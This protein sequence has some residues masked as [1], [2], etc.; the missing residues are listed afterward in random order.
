MRVQWQTPSDDGGVGISNYTLTLT[1]D[2]G[3]SRTKTTN[4][5]ERVLLFNYTTTYSVSVRASNCAGSSN[6]SSPIHV[7]QGYYYLQSTIY[8]II[9]DSSFHSPFLSQLAAV[10]HLFQSMAV[11][12]STG[13][14]RR[15]HR[16][17]S[18]VT[19]ATLPGSGTHHNA[20]TQHGPQTL[21]YSTVHLSLMVNVYLNI[22]VRWSGNN[23]SPLVHSEI[24]KLHCIP[25]TQ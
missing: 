20:S 9:M 11:L 5:T 25:N 14:Q 4:M 2:G 16:S 13:V 18:T 3:E 24:S 19:R 23:F 22:M 10:V 6:P 12:R 21:N 1:S 7:S 15:G 8:V 17:S